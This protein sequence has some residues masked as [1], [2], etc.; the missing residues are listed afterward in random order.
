MTTHIYLIGMM[1]SG[2]S[3]TGKRLA[4]MLGR[5]FADLD[6]VLEQKSAMTIPEIFAQ[7]GEAFFRDQETLVLRE[8]SAQSPGR[9]FATGGGI[10]LRPEN[11]ELMRKTGTAVYLRAS[12]DVLWDRVKDKGHRPLLEVP[13]PKAALRE[14]LSKR[15]E[16]YEKSC[17][18]NVLT[19]GKT[20]EE[21]AREI[22]GL[23]GG[24]MP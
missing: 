18:V 5:D 13:D 4:A 6:A 17:S 8:A 11:A 20:A 19:D 22:V 3:V 7:K 23:L 16:L 14:I 21:V 9:V 1:G 24:K 12:V 2:K 15:R 10:I